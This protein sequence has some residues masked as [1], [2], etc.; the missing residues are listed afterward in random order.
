M[1]AI[2][3]SWWCLGPAMDVARLQ[4]GYREKPPRAGE[5]SWELGTPRRGGVPLGIAGPGLELGSFC[6]SHVFPWRG[7]LPFA[8]S[9]SDAQNVNFIFF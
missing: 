2:L 1:E 8:L 4:R 7:S 6:I 9:P 5:R 3:A